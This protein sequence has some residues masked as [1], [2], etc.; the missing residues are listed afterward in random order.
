LSAL[1]GFRPA[2]DTFRPAARVVEFHPISAGA[3]SVSAHGVVSENRVAPHAM[4]VFDKHSGSDAPGTPQVL[5]QRGT[6][7]ASVNV[8]PANVSSS[9]PPYTPAQIKH[10]YGFDQESYFW[11]TMYINGHVYPIPIAADGSGQTIAIVD[12]YDDPFIL[13]DSQT[14]DQNFAVSQNNSSTLYNAYGPS[15][16]WLTKATPEGTPPVANANWATEIAL[17]VEW[18]HAMAPGAKILLVEAKSSSL[19]DLMGAVDYARRQAGVSVVSMSWGAG[20]FSGESY[21]DSY[22]TSQ[23]GQGITFIASSGDTPGTEYPSVSPNVLAI[24]GTT[25]NLNSDNSYSYETAWSGSGGGVTAYDSKSQVPDAAYDADPNTGFYVYNTTYGTGW[26]EVGGTSAG[27]PQWAAMIA[28]ANEGRLWSNYL[29]TLDGP[30]QTLPAVDAYLPLSDFHVIGGTYNTQTGW[31][32]PV[33]NKMIN[34]LLTNQ[35]V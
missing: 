6:P 10:A 23:N 26:S 4:N 3:P 33:A 21:Y 18:A 8:T 19:S 17:D 34:D 30:T 16:S 20:E 25:L 13:S 24:G 15:S 29:G 14:F 7:L 2:N 27:A 22:F 5:D 9:T 32:T 12:A 31:G 11:R 28:I 1:A 35:Y